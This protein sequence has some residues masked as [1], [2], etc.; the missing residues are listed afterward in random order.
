MTRLTEAQYDAYRRRGRGLTPAESSS[1]PI[2]DRSSASVTLTLPLPPSVNDL[3][4]VNPSTGQKFLVPEQKAYRAEVI[5]IARITLRDA[6]P[7]LG[8]LDVWMRVHLANRRRTDISN[9]IKAIEDALTHARV[10]KDDSQIDRWVIERVIDPD[11]PEF[12]TI[13]IRELAP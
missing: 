12:V 10:Y 1:G 9:R 2:P 5:G 4:D 6:P 11:Q 3:Y 7:L 13:E 8:R